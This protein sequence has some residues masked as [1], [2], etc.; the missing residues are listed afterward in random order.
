[1]NIFEKLLNYFGFDLTRINNTVGNELYRI[2]FPGSRHDFNGFVRID[3]GL[4]GYRITKKRTL[5]EQYYKIYDR[6]GPAER[7]HLDYHQ[8]RLN[9]FKPSL[10]QTQCWEELLI[11]A[12][13]MQK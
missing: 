7:S 5:V 4:V 2:A 10:T 13:A 11:L 1:M 6:L 12:K 8:D 9:T 3:L